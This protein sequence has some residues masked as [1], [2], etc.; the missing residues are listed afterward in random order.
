MI[1]ILLLGVPVP[2]A[3]FLL[4]VVAGVWRDGVCRDDEVLEYDVPGK[5]LTCLRTEE[6]TDSAE[7][8]T[9]DR[10]SFW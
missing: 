9:T 6:L 1:S 7:D 8:P 10:T 3:L 2:A 5:S 4:G